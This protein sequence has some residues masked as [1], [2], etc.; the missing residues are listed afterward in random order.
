MYLS[1]VLGIF[2][3]IL[4]NYSYIV[5]T[6]KIDYLLCLVKI[7]RIFRSGG[8]RF[9]H[10]VL[11]QNTPAHLARIKAVPHFPNRFVQLECPVRLKPA[12]T[13]HPQL[14]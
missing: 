2:V 11:N 1:E 3:R 4:R 9:R 13:V 6:A 8:N 14:I 7:L 10:S 5:L 12:Y